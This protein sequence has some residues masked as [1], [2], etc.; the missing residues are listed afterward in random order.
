MSARKIKIIMIIK[1][2]SK[3]NSNRH[4]SEFFDSLEY[5]I[6]LCDKDLLVVI[7]K[8]K[9]F[10]TW[11][12]T[13]NS[14]HLLENLVDQ[15]TLQR[16]KKS[17]IKGRTFRFEKTLQLG[18]R[19][20]HIEF[21]TKVITLSDNNAYL[22]IQ[23]AVNN[24][25]QQIGH[26]VK[27]HSELAN[28]NQQL[29]AEA[30]NEAEAA[31]VAKSM[32]LASM[33]HELRTPMNGILGMVQQMF[34]SDLSA[35][36]QSLLHTI[37][38]SGDQLLYII[39]QVLD[40]SKIEANKIELHKESIDIKTLTKSVIAIC[41]STNFDNTQ[42]T[43]EAKLTP[44]YIPNVLADD[45]RLKQILINL[46]NNAIKFTSLGTV[47]LEL[48]LNT[49]TSKSCNIG[50]AV[51]DTGV[52]IPQDKVE[53]L[54]KAFSQQDASTTR[55]YGGTGLGLTI[56]DQLIKL[57]GGEIHVTSQVDKGSQFSFDLCFPI[58]QQPH[59]TQLPKKMN[60][61]V[62]LTSNKNIL[63]VDD[64]R[65]NRK[66]ISMAFDSTEA[67]LFM[68]ES[69]KEAIALFKKHA[70]DI[71]LMDCLMPN[72]DGFEATRQIRTLE[73]NGMS[74]LII[75]ITASASEEIGSKAK[76]SGMDDIMLK[77]FKFD[78]LLS[79]VNYWLEL[80]NN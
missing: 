65:I 70:M 66:I 57:M 5:G 55:N 37:E 12:D 52:G 67:N 35:D 46:V 3:N 10:Q 1:E 62:D 17:I 59:R 77:P 28:K 50:F 25:A 60:K 18:Q 58:S 48:S 19:N 73:T 33:S 42:L 43:V 30:K 15:S 32:F 56:S 71:V 41:S 61:P 4:I 29:L 24:S 78:E 38:Q 63:V 79:K 45:V 53:H 8:N 2:S 36:Q 75:A 21:S 74:A 9:V 22:I 7:E 72:M 80:K 23:G 11:L 16:I 26:M 39:N 76:D 20:E 64:T 14:G 34:K 47:I 13:T 51:I 69:G 68:A 44:H 31:N 27:E 54:F 49:I 40:F 6:A